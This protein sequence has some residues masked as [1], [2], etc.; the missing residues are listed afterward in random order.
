LKK[1]ADG[2][3]MKPKGLRKSRVHS[4]G[5]LCQ[6]SYSHNHDD[7]GDPSE[8]CSRQVDRPAPLRLKL[9]Q[10]QIVDVSCRL[11]WRSMRKDSFANFSSKAIGNGSSTPAP[12]AHLSD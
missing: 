3:G 1:F 9:L 5:K 7:A 10:R 6:T 4:S 2:A 8:S 11:F 12:A